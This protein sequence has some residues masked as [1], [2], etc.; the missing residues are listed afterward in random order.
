V[1]IKDKLPNFLQTKEK[2]GMLPPSF[3]QLALSA[4]ENRRDGQRVIQASAFD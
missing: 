4:L 3:A 2:Q 1:Y